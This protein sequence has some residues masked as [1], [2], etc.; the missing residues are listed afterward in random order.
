MMLGGE[1]GGNLHLLIT[2]NLSEHAL[3]YSVYTSCLSKINEAE[4]IKYTLQLSPMI[5]T[6]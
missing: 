5:L 1:K 6:K 2:Y 4:D 3:F